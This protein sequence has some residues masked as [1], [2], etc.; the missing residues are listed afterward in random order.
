M[1]SEMQEN[2]WLFYSI[3][4]PVDRPIRT[5]PTDYQC[6]AWYPGVFRFKARDMP[7]YPFVIWWVF[8]ILH[9]FSNRD[10]G[11]FIIRSG[12]KVIHRS[13]I[14][15]RYFRFPFMAQDDIQ[16]GDTWTDPTERGKGLA[17]IALESVLKRPSCRKHTCWY[18][19]E[20]ENRAS[21]R[22]AEK[23]GFTLA[24]R[25]IRTRRFGL[26]ILGRFVLTEH[27]VRK[28]TEQSVTMGE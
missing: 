5:L 26:S 3:V 20:P 17:T 8:H 24:G 23:A 10:Y 27:A 19:V 11:L 12:S 14:T 15:P 7:A 6:E 2:N 28:E 16:I 22:V 18:V 1:K 13:V 25:G 4:I 9:V 21:I